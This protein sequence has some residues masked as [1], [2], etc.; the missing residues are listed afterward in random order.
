MAHKNVPIVIL[1]MRIVYPVA[2]SFRII[3]TCGLFFTTTAVAAPK[4]AVFRLSAGPSDCAASLIEGRAGLVVTANHCVTARRKIHLVDV[5]GLKTQAVLLA[6][7]RVND[8][9]L[10]YAATLKDHA[11]YAVRDTKLRVGE[12]VVV[13]GHPMVSLQRKIPALRSMLAFSQFEGS[14]SVVGA[15]LV[16][17]DVAFNPG[18]SGGPV[19]DENGAFCGVASRKLRGEH[20]SFATTVGPV[21]R[22]LDQPRIEKVTGRLSVFWDLHAPLWLGGSFGFGVRPQLELWDR[23]GVEGN[24]VF[25]VGARWQAYDSGSVSWYGTSASIFGRFRLAAGS[26]STAIEGGVL[27]TQKRTL[28]AEDTQERVRF[29]TTLGQGAWGGFVRVGQN[30]WEITTTIVIQPQGMD[31]SL[32]IGRRFSGAGRHF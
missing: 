28:E 12:K 16:Q 24:W 19:L 32:S 17:L 25:P 15:D 29:T 21:K 10:L 23:L 7:D 22:L 18:V 27:V 9:A 2:M 4:G 14:V 11:G 26:L 20:L 3:V 8:V 6:T 13:H 30:G 5:N 31:S 1:N